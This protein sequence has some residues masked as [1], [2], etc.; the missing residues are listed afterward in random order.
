MSDFIG[1]PE[2]FFKRITQDDM[3]LFDEFPPD[4]P[5]W[6]G[7]FDNEKLG[8]RGVRVL[9]FACFANAT[10]IVNK[11]LAKKSKIEL[12]VP[13]AFSFSRLLKKIFGLQTHDA[14]RFPGVV[15]NIAADSNRALRCAIVAG[16]L[17]LVKLLLAKKSAAELAVPIPFSITR[18]FKKIFGFETYDEYQFPEVVR[19]IAVDNNMAL[20]VALAGSHREI[21]KVFLAKEPDGSY[22]FP[23]VMNNIASGDNIALR[24]AAEHGYVD[25]MKDLL[26][27]KPDGTYEFPEVVKNIGAEHNSVLSGACMSANVEALKLLLARNENGTYQFPDVVKS[28]ADEDNICLCRAVRGGSIENVKLFLARKSDGSYQFPDVVGKIA[29]ENNRALCVAAGLGNIEMVR[30]LLSQ[31]SDGTY[32]FPAV[33]NALSDDLNV[34]LNMAI[35]KRHSDVVNFLLS[36]ESVFT[37]TENNMGKYGSHITLFVETYLENIR[38]R[39]NQNTPLYLNKKDASFACAILSNLIRTNASLDKLNLL[40]EIP[41]VARLATKK[42]N[43]LLGLASRMKNTIAHERLIEIPAFKAQNT[44]GFF[45]AYRPKKREE[46]IQVP[47]SA[48]SINSLI[49]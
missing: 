10:H 49:V 4:H 16:R 9:P 5:Q 46:S 29:A 6:M 21:V 30:L 38:A 44:Q 48:S 17:E 32:E 35:E 40:L 31:H 39:R 45:L 25:I 28:I 18:F 42:I 15:S 12:D 27:Q 37:Q 23:E 22:Q 11:L 36:F 33:V 47:L 24:L 20:T 2:G 7:S 3:T 1:V 19:N 34:V 14:Y 13:I 8:V 26:A 41:D 43:T